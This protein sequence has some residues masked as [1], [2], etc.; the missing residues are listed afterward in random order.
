MSDL[1][2]LS[3]ALGRLGAAGDGAEGAGGQTPPAPVVP[4]ILPPGAV[5]ADIGLRQIQE[6]YLGL[7]MQSVRMDSTYGPNVPCDVQTHHNNAVRAYQAA[8]QSVFDQILKQNPK[9]Q[10]V[11]YLYNAD[12]SLKTTTNKPRPLIPTV[13]SIP[14]C[15]QNAPM[16]AGYPAPFG[17]LP[18][19]AWIIIAIVAGA[20]AVKLTEVVIMNWPTAAIDTARAQAVWVQTKLNCIDRTMKDKNLSRMDATM[21]CRGET[22]EAPV[23][24]GNMSLSTFLLLLGLGAVS[25]FVLYKAFSS[26]KEPER[27][28]EVEALAGSRPRRR[29]RA[30]LIRGSRCS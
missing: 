25:S 1:D 19:L 3:Y 22:G 27:D 12:G 10:I 11:Q 24:S 9:F 7:Q 21:L 30:R 17:A 29:K 26:M 23:S 15:A 28:R 5:P 18:A 2:R 14:G 13:Y 20:T 8:A 6:L 4:Q 16:F